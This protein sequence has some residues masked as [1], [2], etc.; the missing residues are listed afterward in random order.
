MVVSS[1]IMRLRLPDLLKGFRYAV[2]LHVRV[3]VF[4]PAVALA[5]HLTLERLQTNVLV[6]VLLQIFCLV[7]P[8]VTAEAG[9][10]GGTLIGEL[11][12][13]LGDDAEA[14]GTCY[15]LNAGERSAGRFGLVLLQ[16]FAQGRGSVKSCSTRVAQVL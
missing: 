15:S 12:N 9:G 14:A 2:R 7:E 16:V 1:G 13:W 5:A 3:P 6:H 11:A 10:Q 4:L 8:L